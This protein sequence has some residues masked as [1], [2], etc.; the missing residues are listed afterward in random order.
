MYINYFSQWVQKYLEIMANLPDQGLNI[1]WLNGVNR[2][3]ADPTVSAEQVPN[4]WDSHAVV[5][6][7][8][9]NTGTL[10]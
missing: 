4:V 7:G 1:T 10:G 9:G 5:E 2:Y 3:F 6:V 8:K